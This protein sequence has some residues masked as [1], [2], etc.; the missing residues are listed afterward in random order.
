ML[1]VM[2]FRTLMAYAPPSWDRT[3]AWGSDQLL[4]TLVPDLRRRVA[5]NLQLVY[6]KTQTPEQLAAFARR[7]RRN[8]ATTLIEFMRLS[9]CGPEDLLRRTRTYGQIHL[10]RALQAGRGVLLVTAH[11]GSYEVAG[12]YCA[13]FGLPITVLARARDDEL[14]EQFVTRTRSQHHIRV[15]H[16]TAWREA[17]KVLREGGMVGVLADQAVNTGGV[18][19][20]F[21]GQPAA[22]AVGPVLMA[23]QTG[24]AVLPCFVTRDANGRLT[25]ELHAPLA[26]PDTGDAEADLRAA[27]QALND[28]LS[29]QIRYKPEEWQ[30]LHRRWKT[31]RSVRRHVP[32]LSRAMAADVEEQ[33]AARSYASAP[34]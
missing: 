13:A 8:L 23:Q 4:G 34:R 27:V 22:T 3:I 14:T 10:R 20:E 33:P 12:A 5:A 28:V 1:S 6:G 9:E 29:A 11:Y 24:A 2:A 18:M 32:K 16:K 7:V 30:W 26:L 15:I 17:V 25:V 31:P 21:L 19:A